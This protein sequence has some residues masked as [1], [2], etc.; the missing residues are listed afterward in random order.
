MAQAQMPVQGDPEYGDQVATA[1]QVAAVP[2]TEEPLTEPLVDTGESVVPEAPVVQPA[3]QAVNV[4]PR[5]A[6]AATNLM[7]LPPEVL[8]QEKRQKS[9][10][11]AQYE[12]GMLWEVLASSP[13]A[14]P[15][16]RAVANELKGR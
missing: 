16:V 5:Y 9:P 11:E 14:S 12:A 6:G 8:F 1:E 15:I 4:G 3:Q 10:V 13:Q 2:P 7:R